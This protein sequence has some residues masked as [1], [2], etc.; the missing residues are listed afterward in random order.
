[1]NHK[2]LMG[3]VA[4]VAALLLRSTPTAAQGDPYDGLKLLGVGHHFKDDGGATLD[5]MAFH[6]KY[7]ERVVGMYFASGSRSVHFYMNAAVWDKLKQQLVK[8]RDAWQ[9]LDERT[10]Q[11]AASVQGY[12]IAGKRA[13]LKIGIQG[14]TAL[15][16]KQMLLISSSNAA[17][18]QQIVISLMAD[19]LEDLVNDF[20]KVD[21]LLRNP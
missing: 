19:Q 3:L 5:M 16:P 21:T 18:G 9:T 2:I 4:L 11:S 12:T 8:A 10:F 1:M 14:A 13:T 7:N 15:Q 17:P 6:T 20:S